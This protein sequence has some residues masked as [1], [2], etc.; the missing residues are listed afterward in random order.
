MLTCLSL[1]FLAAL[2]GPPDPVPVSTYVGRERQLHIHIPRIVGDSAR[3][4]IDGNLDE[5]AWSRAAVLA[6]FSQFSP[7][8]GIPAA[9]ST[10]VLM[11]YSANALYVGVRAYESH[12]AV[13]VTLADRDKIAADDN[14]QLI[15]GTFHD[16][17]QA[18]V[19]AVNPIGVQMDGTIVETGRPNSG[20]FAPT[21]AGRTAPD[22]N[23]DFVF[24]SKGHLTDYGY[25]VEIRIPFKSLK[26]QSADVQSW[27]V[28][29]VREVQH[30]GYEDSWAPAKRSGASFL[31]QSGSIDGLTGFDRGV[32]LD[33]NPVV[34][35]KATGAPGPTGWGYTHPTPQFGLTSRWGLTNNLTM[36][37]TVRP[38]FA[39][40]ESDAGQ[41]VLDPRRAIRFAEKRPFFLDGLEQFSVP[42]SLIYTRRIASPNEALK[43]TGKVAGTSVGFLSAS[44]NASLSP[45]GRDATYYNV[46]RAQR[47]VGGESRIG[48]AYTDRVVGTDYN[49]VADVDGRLLFGGVYTEQFQ[50]ARSFDHTSGTYRAAPLW[51]DIF[52]RNGKRYQFRYALTG[53]DDNFRAPTGFISRGAIVHGAAD[54][55][56]SWFYNRGNA[57]ESVTEDILY[58]DI[59]EY[60]HFGHGDAQDKKFHVSTSAA[61]RGGW[62]VL[63]AIYWESFGWDK[64][65]YS[66]YQIERTVGTKVDTIPFT[67]VGR[68]P[69]RDYVATVTTPQWARFSASVTYIGGQD[70][71][72]FEWAQADIHYVSATL[73]VRPSDQLR[74]TGTLAYEDYYRRTDGSVAGRT[75]IPRLKL[76][77]QLTRS[78]FIRAVGEYDL[79]EHDDL[80]DETRTFYPL[81]ISG[82]KAVASRSAQLHGDYLFSYQPLPGTVLFFGYGSEADAN[83]NPID[84]FTWQPLRRANDY[85]FVKY[86]Y[87]FRL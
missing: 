48:M 26:Y 3:I 61:L 47:D 49:R 86:S 62:Q 35:R 9:D 53:I 68:I 36:S 63:G 54:N 17:R 15:L 84:R 21:L 38:D 85:F 4:V 16:H 82:Q 60:S 40:V 74:V 42:N 70:E 73:N 59:W 51:E 23:Q 80:R 41:I 75:S 66:N 1:A 56:V 18:Y 87:L 76:E 20:G 57:I 37:G 78:I 19:F 33:M 7:Q 6:G 39:E 65:L 11:W 77:Y 10:R 79:A 2:G 72:F 50:Y 44:D 29:V 67:G 71:N 43:L 12:G 5:D 64:T 32:V 28:N 13:H 46:M 31:A 34:T 25:E 45:T 83:A 52:S 27:D 22:L 8:D 24:Q 30:S 69:N 81:I 58:D 55:R 14:V